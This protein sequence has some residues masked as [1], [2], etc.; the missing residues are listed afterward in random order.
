MNTV[1]W[2]GSVDSVVDTDGLHLDATHAVAISVD[3]DSGKAGLTPPGT[4]GVLD[5]VVV[6]GVADSKNDVI[7]VGSTVGV[8]DTA[9][10]VSEGTTSIDHHG[11]GALS[12]AG[13]VY[14]QDSFF[15]A[16]VRLDLDNTRALVLTGAWSMGVRVVRG[17]HDLVGDGIVVHEASDTAIALVTLGVAIKLLLL[18]EIVKSSVLDLP[19]GLES[20]S[21]RE[22]PAVTATL[23]LDG[24]DSA[25]ASPVDRGGVVGDPSKDRGLVLLPHGGVTAEELAKL[26]LSPIREVVV[27]HSVG[28]SDIRVDFSD[29]LVLLDEVSESELV[30]FNGGVGLAPLSYVVQELELVLSNDVSDGV[31]RDSGRGDASEG[32]GSE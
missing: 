3:L 26:L 27:A 30:L 22:N 23:V 11:N 7:D 31:H 21:S 2:E 14:V 28:V 5:D 25:L 24:T 20:S 9:G 12:N 8:D 13:L 32:E 17:L 4:P 18:R 19:V 15:N 6:G 10:V 16:R 1:C 29:P